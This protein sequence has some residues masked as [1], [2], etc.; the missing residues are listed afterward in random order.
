MSDKQRLGDFLIRAK[1][2]WSRFD[3]GKNCQITLRVFKNAFCFLRA[4][5]FKRS[6]YFYVCLLSFLAATCFRCIYENC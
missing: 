5:L 3:R 6:L 2:K 1:Q 4:N